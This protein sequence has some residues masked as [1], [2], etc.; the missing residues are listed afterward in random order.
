MIAG[1]QYDNDIFR[2]RIY[3]SHPLLDENNTSTIYRVRF[4]GEPIAL[5]L[6]VTAADGYNGEIKLLLCVDVNGVV[7]GVRPVRHKETP[8]LG[9]GIEPK[10][11]DWIYQFANT[12]LSNMGKS[13]WAVKKNGGHF[14]ALTGATITSRAVIRAVHKGLQYVQ[15]EGSS[16]YTVASMGEEIK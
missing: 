15:M 8:G 11:S 9:D 7:K 3:R 2:D 6:S 1:D 16:L 14:D 13:A 4:Q 10:K 5:V 12:S